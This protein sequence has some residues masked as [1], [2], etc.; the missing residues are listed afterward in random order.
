MKSTKSPRLLTLAAVV[1]VV[2]ALYFAKV[3]LVPLA[4]SALLAFLLSPLVSRM[5]GFHVHPEHFL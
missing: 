2:T 5:R 3:V 4:I 1:V